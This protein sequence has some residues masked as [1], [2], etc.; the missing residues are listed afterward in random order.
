VVVVSTE[1]DSV[2]VVFTEEGSE[3]AVSVGVASGEVASTAEDSVVVAAIS[4]QWEA[5]SSLTAELLH[6]TDAT[7]AATIGTGAAGA[8]IGVVTI[9]DS[10]IMSFS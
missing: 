7:G 3:A 10:L 5:D 6:G 9:T 1:E 2:V 8:A 4:I